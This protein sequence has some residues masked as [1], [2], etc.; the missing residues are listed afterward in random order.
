MGERAAALDEK[1]KQLDESFKTMLA[2]IPNVPHESVP[3]GK[4]RGRERR[5]AAVGSAAPV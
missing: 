3:V 5:G 1:V 4:T 2:G